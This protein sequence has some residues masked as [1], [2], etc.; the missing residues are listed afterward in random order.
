MAHEYGHAIQNRLHLQG[1]PT[2]VLE[3]QADCFAGS[4]SQMRRGSLGRVPRRGPDQL[5]GAVAGMLSIRDQPGLGAVS[6]GARQRVRPDPRVPGRLRTGPEE[7]RGVHRP[8]TS[9]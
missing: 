7:V 8:T 9:R 6:T 1:L 3:Q 2:I 5:D 4:W